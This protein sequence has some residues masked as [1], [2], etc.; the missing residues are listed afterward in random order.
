MFSIRNGVLD[1]W[2]FWGPNMRIVQKH[3]FTHTNTNNIFQSRVDMCVYGLVYRIFEN[4]IK[5][6]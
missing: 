1:S 2:Q 3:T 5:Y 6:V 4:N